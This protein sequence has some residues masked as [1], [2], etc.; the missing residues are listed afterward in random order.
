[1][2]RA[3]TYKPIKFR[4]IPCPPRNTVT[5]SVVSVLMNRATRSVLNGGF[6]VHRL[7]AIEAPV[8][9]SITTMSLVFLMSTGSNEVGAFHLYV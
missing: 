6:V 7:A 8:S 3:I 5:V 9:T 2:W 4:S 1:M